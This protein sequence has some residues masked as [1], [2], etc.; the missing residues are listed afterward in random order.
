[1]FYTE[2]YYLCRKIKVY[3]RFHTHIKQYNCIMKHILY[4][5]SIIGYCLLLCTENTYAVPA[6][7]SPI[8]Y[9]LPDGSSITLQITGDERQHSLWSSD[10]YLLLQ[11]E[12]DFLYYA[13]IDSNNK[14][15][16]TSTRAHDIEERTTE[17]LYTLNKID[18]TKISQLYKRY[19]AERPSRIAPKRNSEQIR[20]F[21]TIGQ[22]PSL[23]ILAHFAD[24][25][26]SQSDPKDAFHRLLNESG[27]ADNKA[28]GSARDYFVAASGGQFLPD[29]EVVGPVR[30]EKNLSYYGNNGA[31]G[32]DLHA[33]DAIIEACQALDA[34]IDF[35]K[36]DLDNDGEIDNVYLF[37]AGKGEADGGAASTIW[38][39]SWEIT[40]AYPD[41]TFYFD[42]KKLNRYACSNEIS[43]NKLVGIGTFCHEFSHVL[44]LPDLYDTE[45]G[46]AFA[47]GTWDIMASGPYNNNGYTPPTY[48]AYERMVLNW[49]TPTELTEAASVSLDT[50]SQNVAYIVRTERTEEYFLFENR[51]KNGWDKYIPG[52]GML[53]WHIDYDR[54]Y[55]FQNKANNDASHQRIDI[56]EA[57]NLK[58]ET[59]RDSDAFPGSYN[60]TSFTDNT[61]PGMKT[62]SDAKLDKPITNIV[63]LN[64]KIYFDVLG[65]TLS[66]PAT[67][68]LEADNIDSTSFTARWSKEALSTHYLL[69]VYSI[70]INSSTGKE[71]KSYVSGYR[72]KSVGNVTQCDIT[73]LTPDTEYHY[74]VYTA[75]SL[76]TG[77][78]SNVISVHTLSAPND[79]EALKHLQTP[80]LHINLNAN[81][82]II[83]CNSL[84]GE[85]IEIYNMGGQI[86]GR[87]QIAHGVGFRFIRPS[88]GIYYIN[89]GHHRYKLLL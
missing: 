85:K 58:T 63:E 14:F 62:W 38:P 13:T 72:K 80:P 18:K 60:I 69:D 84:A 66:M 46:T 87:G 48:S 75:D 2:K 71:T 17:E 86:V 68:A 55:W 81:E 67:T 59:T 11:G 23:V 8:L 29:F 70:K 6:A 1:M 52:H 41:T 34:E 50:I 16:P 40:S 26:F 39:H 27:Y 57:D 51:Q 54:N 33:E 45:Y 89:I 36:Y 73:D 77:V 21:P 65:G 25:E 76:H 3:K 49:L 31:Y 28:T 32:G 44:G 10:G 5:L 4:S 83:I 15:I 24:N 79:I 30:L 9:T 7:P 19:N 64:G 82:A 37:Y 12:D 22:Q 42:G 35:S 56:E 20:N 61:L 88:A 78:A 53:I 47:P 74:V 43:R